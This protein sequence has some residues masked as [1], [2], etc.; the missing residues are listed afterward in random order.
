MLSDLIV[1]NI[2]SKYKKVGK[3]S[4]QG[5]CAAVLI[6]EENG[7]PGVQ[8]VAKV[9]VLSSDI[10]SKVFFTELEIMSRMHHPSILPVVGFGF[11]NFK[12]D[13]FDLTSVPIMIT[14]YM[15]NLSLE[16]VLKKEENSLSPPGW[17]T[18]TKYIVAIGISL[19]ML[20]LHSRNIVHR[21]LK[22]ANILLDENYY[23]KI[24]DFGT[25]KAKKENADLMN[26]YIGTP[27]YMA[28]EMS[29]GDY[30]SSVDVFSFGLI[31]FNIITG[32]KIEKK[33]I[34]N[35]RYIVGK[36]CNE[37]QFNFLESCWDSN[38][39][40]RKTFAE[41]ISELVNISF[42]DEDEGIDFDQIRDYIRNFDEARIFITDK[43]PFADLMVDDKMKE[44]IK[45]RVYQHSSLL[46]SDY[47]PLGDD[48]FPSPSSASLP[49]KIIEE[50]VIRPTTMKVP[51][52]NKE[53]Q[54]DIGNSN[55]AVIRLPSTPI[56][57]HIDEIPKYYGL[58]LENKE[59]INKATN[60]DIKSLMQLGQYILHGQNGFTASPNVAIKIFQKA[61][62]QGCSDGF[63]EIGN[64]YLR[65]N[66]VE[67][68][69]EEAIRFYEKAIEAGN[70][71]ALCNYG[72]I[73]Y[74]RYE[75][76]NDKKDLEIAVDCFKRAIDLNGNATAMHHYAHL[77][78]SGKLSVLDKFSSDP[79]Q[80]K[81][82]AHNY[83]K[84]AAE[85][86][87]IASMHTYAYI[88]YK[89]WKEKQE[90][91]TKFTVQDLIDLELAEKYMMAAVE[92]GEKESQNTLKKIQKAISM[93]RKA[94]KK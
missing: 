33:Q 47:D 70:S 9:T 17:N 29:E 49:T 91:K 8:Y 14:P 35:K 23:P 76:K 34:H 72:S 31:L 36:H 6:I 7:K 75:N 54:T 85:I 74:S 82:I 28:N 41:I 16:S 1:D 59:F 73:Y 87:N 61:A 32:T 38:P 93:T 89:D 90:S 55:A 60:G 37:Y 69:E 43:S 80:N 30:D 4:E 92:K 71:S 5:A 21:D 24:A 26:T 64:M 67:Q 81:R 68:N 25:S 40:K 53:V 79:E 19:G 10:A 18:T 27:Y 2:W 44:M 42:W 50:P 78:L 52:V 63:F 45:R 56:L 83:I 57:F 51:T 88:T 58:S 11:A 22:P 65:G 3:L 48:I 77:I 86:G 15:K 66:G 12:D 94:M 20:Y 62:K 46:S 84:K 13:R 39:F